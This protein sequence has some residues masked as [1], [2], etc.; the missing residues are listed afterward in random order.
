M[1]CISD[2]KKEC[3]AIAKIKSIESNPAVVNESEKVAEATKRKTKHGCESLHETRKKRAREVEATER[4]QNLVKHVSNGEL[5][6]HVS[7]VHERDT[8]D[9]LRSRQ[10]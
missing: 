2:F 5:G 3:N 9:F 10:A 8:A 1:G 4:N 7:T 6:D